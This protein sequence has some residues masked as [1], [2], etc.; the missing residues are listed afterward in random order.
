MRTRGGRR[1]GLPHLGGQSLDNIS[2]Q[3]ARHQRRRIP[4]PKLLHQIAHVL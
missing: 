3:P 4:H 1:K 2:G